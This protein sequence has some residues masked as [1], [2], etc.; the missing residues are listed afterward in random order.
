MPPDHPPKL[1]LS[2]P[3]QDDCIAVKQ[4]AQARKI[5]KVIR[6]DGFCPSRGIGHLPR[7]EQSARNVPHELGHKTEDKVPCYKQYQ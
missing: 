4:G 6:Q 5:R 3:F 7:K 1:P 2:P